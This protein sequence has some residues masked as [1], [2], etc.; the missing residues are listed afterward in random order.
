MDHVSKIGER[1]RT[2]RE[3]K[4]L[5]QQGLADSLHVKRETINM[6]ENGFRDLK[7]GSVVLLADFFN[8]SADYL[9]GRSACKSPDI[10]IQAICKKTG[11]W[12]EAVERLL[13]LK[14]SER[15]ALIGGDPEGL[16]DF[17]E[18]PQWEYDAF[19]VCIN[20]FL[21]DNF[22]PALATKAYHVAEES[23]KVQKTSIET[24]DKA[25]AAVA[26]IDPELRVLAPI[27]SQVFYR[28][29]VENYS[30]KIA[31]NIIEGMKYWLEL[32]EGK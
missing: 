6:W 2:L 11:L 24:I 29:R 26:D 25:R 10:D 12:P 23:K 1:I 15:K 30:K 20:L 19:S 3:E 5:T 16:M 17:D 7:T 22:S 27:E 32:K 21:L 18:I 14:N 9:L 28:Y 13:A 8:V 4:G 31:G